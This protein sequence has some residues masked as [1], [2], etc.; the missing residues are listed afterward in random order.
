MLNHLY[1]RTLALAASR[2]AM[3]AMAAISFA[4][5]SF[6]PL[7]PDI[8]L[9]P[10]ILSQPR[11]AW[12]IAGVCTVASV[13]GGFVG[14][15][16]GYFLFDAVGRLVLEFYHAMDK[17]EALKAAFAQWGAWIII[18]KGLTPIPYKLVTIASGVAEFNLLTFALASLL[19]R[20][21]RFFLLAA[22]LW[23]F[24]EPVREFIERRLM[25]VTSAVAAALV[26]GFLVLRYL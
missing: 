13:L 1:S 16:I 12:L 22:L 7:P 2:H 15:A 19:S 4:E 24:G 14:Y 17:Y 20:S 10:M 25:L 5:S 3:W 18:L 21:L 11:R 8:L 9:I 23:R 6:F 26:G